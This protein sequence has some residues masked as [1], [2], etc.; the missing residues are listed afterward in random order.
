MPGSS[1]QSAA[2]SQYLAAIERIDEMARL[3]AKV[4]L[5]R[6]WYARRN[7]TFC[8]K[9]GH[10]QVGGLYPA[11]FSTVITLLLLSV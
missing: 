11:S 4:G 8:L 3:Q 7:A 2:D 10:L 6:E 1:F 9:M 5:Y